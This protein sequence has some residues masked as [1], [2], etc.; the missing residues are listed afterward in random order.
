[1]LWWIGFSEAFNNVNF[2]RA[3]AEVL[4][5]SVLVAGLVWAIA[6]AVNRGSK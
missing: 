3:C 5:V 2:G 6:Y 4:I 1:M